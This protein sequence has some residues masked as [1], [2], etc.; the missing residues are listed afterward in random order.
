MPSIKKHTARAAIVSSTI[1]LLLILAGCS[2]PNSKSDFDPDKGVHPAGWYPGG[3]MTAALNSGVSSCADCHGADYRGGISGV[4]CRRC[5]IN[6]VPG[7]FSCAEC[8]GFPPNGS[9]FPNT[10]GTHA[11]HQF[12]NVYCTACHYNI[13]GTSL[14]DN[15]VANVIFD[16][17]F[18][19][20]TGGAPSYDTGTQTCVNVSCHGGQVTPNWFTGTISLTDTTQCSLCHQY[21]VAQYNSYY[22]GQHQM[23]LVDVGAVCTD[24]HDP[25]RL[26]TVHFNDLNTPQM[27]YAG[28][29]LNTFLNWD[30]SSC[31]FTCHISSQQHDRTMT[32]W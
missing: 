18:Q 3:H 25:A 11:F 31:L 21:A 32:W 9:A 26:A 10:A 29:T 2:S 14:H 12:P 8:H 6:K 23:H 24:C 1:G 27:L 16:P 28:Q 17:T 30:G 19:A 22:S 4:S 7:S 15:G 13:I 5:H 20:E